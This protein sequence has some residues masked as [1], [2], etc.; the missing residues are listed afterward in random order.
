MAGTSD[1]QAVPRL[2]LGVST[3]LLGE[4]VR[5]DGGHKRDRFLTDT[6]GRW[7]DWVPVCPEVECG[8]PT[9]R[10]AMRLVGDPEAPRLLTIKTA[11]D[12]T[13]QMQRW[14][15]GKLQ[16]LAGEG[17]VGYIF[18]SGSPSSGM[19]RIKVYRSTEKGAPAQRVGVGL[20]ARA[21]KERFP[22]LPTED[23]G[24]LH[25]P[26]LREN[27]IERIFALQRYRRLYDGRR[28]AGK[29]VEFHSDHKLQLMA[30]SPKLLKAMGQLVARTEQLSVADLFAAYEKLL[31]ECLSARATVRRNVNAL[32]HMA[33]YFKKQLDAEQRA[34]LVE[35]VEHYRQGLV[36][37][38]VSITL[39][40]H[41]VR[42]FQQPYLGRQTYL[43]PHPLELKLRNH[44]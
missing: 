30:H 21:F 6:L 5:Y 3:C 23:E 16:Q 11:R 31:L 8:L 32:Q 29:L 19:E 33:G 14:I 4:Q 15:P 18:K 27:F 37:L 36:P 25:D 44:A 22:L 2:R 39:I 17:L 26:G 7:V 40:R 42:R 10:E 41:H 1:E 24:R 20:F 35:V 34:E 38:I 9:P 13:P 28:S 12:I 43:A